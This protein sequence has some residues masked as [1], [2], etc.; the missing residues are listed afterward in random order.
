M[1][2]HVHMLEQ[3][4][5]VK[6]VRIQRLLQ[7]YRARKPIGHL[8]QPAEDRIAWCQ[9]KEAYLKEGIAVFADE[10]VAIVDDIDGLKVRNRSRTLP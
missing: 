9:V 8:L 4:F 6:I 7:R 5:P 2:Q 10:S 3:P 1:K